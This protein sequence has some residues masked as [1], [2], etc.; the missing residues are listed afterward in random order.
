MP[1]AHKMSIE[2][3]DQVQVNLRGPWILACEVARRLIEAGKSGG[4]SSTSARSRT[5]A[6][7]AAA[8][9]FML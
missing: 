5:S 9:R 8:R 3:I 6:M 1:S 4:G 2:L 7:T